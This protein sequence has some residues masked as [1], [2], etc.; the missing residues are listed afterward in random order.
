MLRKISET[1]REIVK[2]SG[3]VHINENEVLNVAKKLKD[4]EYKH[5]L[6]SY[7]S[8]LLDYTVEEQVNFLLIYDSINFS[9]WGEPKWN[10]VAKDGK[11]YDGSFGLLEKLLDYYEDTK[12]LDFTKVS[13]EEFKK[14]LEGNIEIPLLE[15]RYNILVEVSKIVNEKLNGNFYRYTKGINSD[16][17]LFKLIIDMFKNFEDVRIIGGRKIYFYK[18]AQLLTSDILHLKEYTEGIHIDV[19]NL[20][21]CSDYKIPQ[22]LRGL[23][24]LNYSDELAA[25]VDNKK[26]L[27]ENS[28]FEAEI[29]ANTI[30][31]IEKIYNCLE[32]KFKK[33]EINDMLWDLS[34][35]EN[36]EFKP[37]H[38]TRTTSY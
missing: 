5:W 18:L 11:K 9:Y 17:V 20:V 23:N 27:G 25:L 2:I 24:V 1:C 4:L 30:V 32:G 36:I 37:Y 21:G 12:N 29:R 16:I 33:I 19:S 6:V 28:R 26:V 22:L 35:D 7:K 31:A 38:L 8:R 10:V 13:L 3:Y 34:H 14:I 15:E